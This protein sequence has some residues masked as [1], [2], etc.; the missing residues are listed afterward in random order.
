MSLQPLGV[1]FIL[2]CLPFAVHAAVIERVVLNRFSGLAI[3]GFDPVAYFTDGKPVLGREEFEAFEAGVI[4]RFYNE[5]DRASLLIRIS[6][7]RSSADTTRSIW[8]AASQWLAT[9]ISGGFPDSGFIYSA[10]NNPATPLLPIP[11]E[12]CGLPTC[13]GRKSGIA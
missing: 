9:H 13:A 2:A 11:P 12:S 4:W 10:A 3:E 7:D 8:R 6:T 5:G 1:L